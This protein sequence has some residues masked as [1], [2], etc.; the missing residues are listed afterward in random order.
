[1]IAVGIPY[2]PRLEGTVPESGLDLGYAINQ[3]MDRLRDDDWALILDHDLVFATRPDHW[4]RAMEGYVAANPE[5]GFFTPYR[6][7]A[8]KRRPWLQPPQVTATYDMRYHRKVGANLAEANRG[9][10]QDITEWEKLPGGN[11]SAGIFLVRKSVWGEVGGFK[12]GFKKEGIDH[13]FHARVRATGRRCYLMK[14]VYLFHSKE[15]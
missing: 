3:F 13:D 5:A 9:Q 11:P 1:M 2:C 14:D 6:W 7:P 10:L 4:Y 8:S 12:N 15:L